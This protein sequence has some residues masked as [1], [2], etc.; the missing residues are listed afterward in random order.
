M[1]KKKMPILH[2]VEVQAVYPV[3]SIVRGKQRLDGCKFVVVY[4]GIA[5]VNKR[6]LSRMGLFS[7]GYGSGHQNLEIEAQRGGP[8]TTTL[9]YVFKEGLFYPEPFAR[10][11]KF[12]DA[13]QSAITNFVPLEQPTLMAIKKRFLIGEISDKSD[14]KAYNIVVCYPV[15]VVNNPLFKQFINNGIP[16]DKVSIEATKVKV[17]YRFENS[18]DVQVAYNEAMAFRAYLLGQMKQR[19]DEN[20]K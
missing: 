2:P 8:H 18:N 9:E 17:E 10:A 14:T 5:D 19:Q 1:T 7:G 13:L 20:T 15:A 3:T 6:T 12:H 4:D 11:N 16:V